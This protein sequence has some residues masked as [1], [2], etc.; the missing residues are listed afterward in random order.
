MSKLFDG[1][2]RIIP[3]RAANLTQALPGRAPCQYRNACWLGCRYGGYFSTQSSTLPVAMATKR[4]TLMPI[5]IVSELLYDRDRRRATGVRVV[6]AVTE[7]RS[8]YKAPL[9]FLC[10]STLNSAW[11][12]M[13]SA[14]DVWP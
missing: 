2:R 14:T 11:I 4:L 13:R 12:L 8:E 10:A 7:Q 6:D 3:G 5:A 1:R 9:I